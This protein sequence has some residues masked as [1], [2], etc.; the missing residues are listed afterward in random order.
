[1]EKGS[2][3]FSEA[4]RNPSLQT[5]SFF[6][7]RNIVPL[8]FL[9]LVI[10]GVGAFFLIRYLGDYFAYDRP[11]VTLA[12]PKGEILSVAFS[13][14]G[15]TIA[16]GSADKTIWLWDSASGEIRH[17]LKEHAAGVRTIAFSPDGKTIA[18]GGDDRELLLWDAANG[19]LRERRHLRYDVMSIAFSPDGQTIVVGSG[20]LY[21]FN[22]ANLNGAFREIATDEFYVLAVAVSPDGKTIAGST[23]GQINLWDVESGSLKRTLA[24]GKVAARSIAFAPDGRRLVGGSGEGK[25]LLWDVPSG[26]LK[27][28]I[29]G[30]RGNTIAVAIPPRGNLLASGSYDYDPDTGSFQ[31][32]IELWDLESGDF[33]KMLVRQKV[34]VISIAV[35]PDGK[36]V[37]GGNGNGTIGLW[38]LE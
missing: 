5:R 36:I 17:S 33:R 10:F 31:G 22:A 25:V 7:W 23:R 12:G 13:P 15:K 16:G 6:R 8:F 19:K 24:K 1:M 29:D 28:T 14:D 34:K 27:R 18:S 37:A 3:D 11:S 21:L 20:A 35:S 4:G 2:S 9:L 30:S 32:E 26:D 38:R